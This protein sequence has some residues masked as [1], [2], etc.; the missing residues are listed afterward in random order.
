MG[1]KDLGKGP[2]S[3]DVAAE[4]GRLLQLRIHDEKG[5]KGRE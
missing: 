5:V 2:P 4:Q 3:I 1:V